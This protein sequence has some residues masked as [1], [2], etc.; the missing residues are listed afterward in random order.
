[1]RVGFDEALL[2][3]N[4]ISGMEMGCADRD[5]RTQFIGFFDEETPTIQ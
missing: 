4:P 3:D 2:T 1:M 5:W